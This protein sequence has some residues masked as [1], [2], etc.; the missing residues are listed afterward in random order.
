MLHFQCLSCGH[1]SFF[2]YLFFF[3]LWEAGLGTDQLREKKLTINK[4]HARY[5]I[6]WWLWQFKPKTSAKVHPGHIQVIKLEHEELSKVTWQTKT[7][8]VIPPGHNESIGASIKMVE[9]WVILKGSSRTICQTSR[10]EVPS[11]SWRQI[12]P[13]NKSLACFEQRGRHFL[14]KLSCIAPIPCT[15][16][17]SSRG[18]T[19]RRFCRRR[20]L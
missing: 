20:I 4:S 8:Y 15:H 9:I 12:F 16:W 11:M 19:F 2:S 6:W 17:F 5:L 1:P 7:Y 10:K 3:S 14:L 18:S 13:N